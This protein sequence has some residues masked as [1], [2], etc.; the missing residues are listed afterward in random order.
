MA[1]LDV[2]TGTWHGNWAYF[3]RKQAGVIYAA[4]KRGDIHM[5]RKQVSDM[6]DTVGDPDAY[7]DDYRQM[8]RFICDNRYD[9]AQAVIDGKKVEWRTVYEERDFIVTQDMFDHLPNT[10]DGYDVNM[11]DIIC[12]EV[13]G[14]VTGTR[15]VSAGWEIVG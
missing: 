13:G 10:V 7:D 11:F 14:T 6:Y 1:Y 3:T 2:L 15:I 4:N 9:L 12:E 5:S 8:V